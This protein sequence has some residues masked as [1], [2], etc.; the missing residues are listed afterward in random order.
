MKFDNGPGLYTKFAALS[1]PL[2]FHQRP[3]TGALGAALLI[4]DNNDNNNITDVCTF[5]T[6]HH[7]A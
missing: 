6:T 3:A 1:R 5:L 2:E 4:I 7:N